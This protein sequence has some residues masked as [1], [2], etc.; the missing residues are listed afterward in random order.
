MAVSIGDAI[1]SLVAFDGRRSGM[2]GE[3][4]GGLKRIVEENIAKVCMTEAREEEEAQKN[5]S[6]KFRVHGS[7]KPRQD[8]QQGGVPLRGMPR[9]AQRSRRHP[10]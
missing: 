5:A 6:E 2:V 4:R 3:D 8:F 10:Q 7:E 1:H 9:P